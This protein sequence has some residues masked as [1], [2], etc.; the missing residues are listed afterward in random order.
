MTPV[1]AQQAEQMI[2]RQRQLAD[3]SNVVNNI[4]LCNSRQMQSF[5]RAS[6]RCSFK[7]RH[8]RV[9]IHAIVTNSDNSSPYQT[10][11]DSRSI[12]ERGITQKHMSSIMCAWQSSTLTSGLPPVISLYHLSSD[13]AAV[14]DRCSSALL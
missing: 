1:G 12:V 7:E 4:V 14:E 2:V 11:P 9:S 10:T 3:Y 5:L 6:V 8:C 13:I